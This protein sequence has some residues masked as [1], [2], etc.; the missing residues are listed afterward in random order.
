MKYYKLTDENDRTL[1]GHQWG[2]GVEHIASGKNT[3][4]LQETIEC[5]SNP[6]LAVFMES[7]YMPF[8]KIAHLWE[9][10][11]SGKIKEYLGLWFKVQKLKTLKRIPFTKVTAEQKRAFAILCVLEVYQEKN[12]KKWASNWF[13]GQDRTKTKAEA[14]QIVEET[15]KLMPIINK[16]RV[17][18]MTDEMRAKHIA[19]R[20]GELAY[21]VHEASQIEYV[22]HWAVTAILAAK[23]KVNLVRVAEKTMAS[24]F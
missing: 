24:A 5:H 1:D 21:A 18:R 4:G 9:C 19:V 22:I 8:P 7:T 3:L 6:F 15:S 2:E 11:A 14:T 23:K 12:F 20:A 16:P 17:G 10:E 13:S